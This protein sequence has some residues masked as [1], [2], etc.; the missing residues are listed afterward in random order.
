MPNITRRRLLAGSAAA[1][2]LPALAR[3]QGAKPRITA[4]SQWSAGSDGAAISALGKR[5]EERGGVWQHNPVP[6]FTT[7]MMNKL[8]AQIMAGDPP[9]IS[10]LKGPEIAAWSKIAPT[11]DISALVKTAGY[12]D[13]VSAEL[14]KSCQPGGHWIALPLQVYRLNTLFLSTKGMER[15]KVSKAPTSWAE[16]N[17]VADKMKAAGMIPLA[18]GG[19]RPDDGQKF[20]IALAGISPEVYRR[21]LMQ[22]D[23]DALNSKEVLA[24]FEQLRKFANYMNPNIAAQPWAVN[25]PAFVKGDMGM[26]LT[27]GWAQGNLFKAGATVADF[28]SGPAPQDSGPPCFDL[29]ADCFIF[30]KSK[31]A[32]LDAGQKLFAEVV[33][34]PST[35]EMYSKITGSIPARTDVSLAGEGFTDGQRNSAQVLRDAIAK[36][37]VVLSLAHNM[38]QPNGI[39]AA[40]ID[41]LTEYVHNSAIP[42]AEGQKKLVAAVASAK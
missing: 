35:Q 25:L 36:D 6:G 14:A 24:A 19:N 17:D 10:Q 21:A 31:S 8:R 2:A 37:R 13:K 11:V 1:L 41:V 42:A 38:A 4:I 9:A 16:F 33:M 26:V 18:N 20:E 27:G 28:S 40:M 5:F 12:A 22:L 30:W 32:D 23:T 39:T 29:N 7:D 15:A 3:A 34:E